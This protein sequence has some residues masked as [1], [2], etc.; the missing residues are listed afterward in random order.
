MPV[1]C[2]IV[3]DHS[4]FRSG[5][6]SLLASEPDIEG[7]GEAEDGRMAVKLAKE[8]RPDVVIMDVRMPELNGIEATRQI[9]SD[10]EG[11][12]VLALSMHRDKRIVASMFRAGAS[13]FVLKD[14]AF[15]EL[16]GAIRKVAASE[17]YLS[18]GLTS[19]VL[20]DYVSRLTAVEPKNSTGLSPREKEVLQL[21]AE[22][23][24]TK[25]IARLLSV[26]VKT[27]D[28][29]RKNVMDKLDLHSIAELT[30]YAIREGITSAEV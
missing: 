27:I 5:L 16:T 19:I 7:V 15:E 12:R 17:T 4:I 25:Q 22:G 14:C 29:H 2:L 9:T 24:S 18:D 28:S 23:K 13:G 6:Q 21:L 26:S 3:D 11:P 8:L 30:K 10:G 20:E 1:K